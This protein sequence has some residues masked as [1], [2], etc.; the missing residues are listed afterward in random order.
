MMKRCY[1]YKSFLDIFVKL[2]NWNRNIVNLKL[3]N[4]FG[5]LENSEATLTSDIFLFSAKKSENKNYYK[6]NGVIFW[7]DKNLMYIE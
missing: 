3:E 6:K 4:N 7:C 2:K 1:T 5:K